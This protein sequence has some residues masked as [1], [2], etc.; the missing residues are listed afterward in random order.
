MT[1][2]ET[3]TTKDIAELIRPHLAEMPGY[4]PVEP[5]DVMARRLGLR[6]DQ[7]SKLDGNENPYGASPKVAEWL[8]RFGQYHIYPDPAQRFDVA[9]HPTAGHLVAKRRESQTDMVQVVF[10]QL[11]PID[12]CDSQRSRGGR[13]RRRR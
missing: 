2:D 5:I 12:E 4:E 10:E 7:I 6:A 8:G 11:A 1:T 3:K 13:D 9:K